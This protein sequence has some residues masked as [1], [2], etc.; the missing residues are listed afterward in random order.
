M[1][2]PELFAKDLSSATDASISSV[3]RAIMYTFA[4]LCTNACL[5]LAWQNPVTGATITSTFAIIKPI[6]LLPPVTRAILPL[7]L[8]KFGTSRFSILLREGMQAEWLMR[9]PRAELRYD[10]ANC[11]HGMDKCYR[12]LTYGSSIP[13]HAVLR[14]VFLHVCAH[15]R[16]L[17]PFECY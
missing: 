10:F 14:Y 15:I 3:A 17:Q 16:S 2:S 9:N 8:N 1:T 7:T 6:P 5:H 11:M 12:D 13:L 4:P